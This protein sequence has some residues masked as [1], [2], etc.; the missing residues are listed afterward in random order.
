MRMAAML[1]LSL[2]T[3]M[4]EIIITLVLHLDTQTEEDGMAIKE[5]IHQLGDE[6]AYVV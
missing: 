4:V 1:G 6:L 5:L 2:I 3:A